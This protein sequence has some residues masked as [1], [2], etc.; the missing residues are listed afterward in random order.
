MRPIR[1][2]CSG[3]ELREELKNVIKC[4]ESMNR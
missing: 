1:D 3:S 4:S 2:V